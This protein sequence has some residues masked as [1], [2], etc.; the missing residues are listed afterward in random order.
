MGLFSFKKKVVK[1]ISGGAWGHLISEHKL[2]VDTLANQI[3]CVEREGTLGEE[4]KV[5]LLRVFK[6]S[7]VQKKGVEVKGW[8]TFDE[9]PDLVLFEGYVT[10]NNEA[11]LEP[12]KKIAPA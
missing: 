3:R 5:T 10:K 7:D 8:E 2:D 6:L 1:E 12:K 11:F 9:H 4:K